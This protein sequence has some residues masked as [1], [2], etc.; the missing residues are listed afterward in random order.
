M[1]I[2]PKPLGFD[3]DEGNLEKNRRKHA[4]TP[5]ESENIFLDSESIILPDDKHSKV[6]ER[7]LI[8]GRSQ[9][10]RCLLVSFTIRNK[11]IRIISARRMHRE[12]VNKYEEAKKGRQD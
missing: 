3:W 10:N 2:I 8:F 4:V 6:E 11:K 5:E 1:R 12:E 7:Y 9:N